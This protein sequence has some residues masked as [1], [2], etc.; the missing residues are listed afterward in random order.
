MMRRMWKGCQEAVGVGV[1]CF[2]WHRSPPRETQ[3]MDI[4]CMRSSCPKAGR[5]FKRKTETYLME[6][7]IS[8][9]REAACFIKM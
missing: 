6:A 4:E 3:V 8:M 1:R 2:S 7:I 9:P 5:L